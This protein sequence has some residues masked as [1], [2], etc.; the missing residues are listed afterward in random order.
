MSTQT[1]SIEELLGNA[2]WMERFAHTLC[3][4]G[5]DLA[6]DA[7]IAA[8]ES[9]AP[10]A[11][12]GRAWFAT[13]MR[14]AFRMRL[15]SSQRRTLREQV[16]PEPQQPPVP[17]VLTQRLLVE[18]RLCDHVLLLTESQREVILLHFYEGMSA[19]AIARQL[20]VPATTIRS[21]LERSLEVL[22]EGLDNESNGDREAWQL[23]L[24]SLSSSY[25]PP[26]SAA[27]GTALGVLAM[28]AKV[29]IAIGIALLLLIGG[30]VKMTIAMQTAKKPVP[31]SAATSEH[32]A[33]FAKLGKEGKQRDAINVKLPSC[34]I[35]GTVRSAD[36]KTTLA[37]ALVLSS[38]DP[39]VISTADSDGRF[40][41]EN[42]PEG[43]LGL[44]ASAEEHK[45]ALQMVEHQCG[46]EVSLVLERGGV[47]VE[48]SVQD[49]GGGTV[50]QASVGLAAVRQH[51][52]GSLPALSDE[53]GH[54]SLRV[55]AG[56]YGLNAYHPAYV[57]SNEFLA[58]GGT[59]LHRDIVLLPAGGIQ[60]RVTEAESGKA[61]ALASIEV[62]GAL[63]GA[64]ASQIVYSDDEG[65]FALSGLPPGRTQLRIRAVGLATNFEIELGLAEER[66]DVEIELGRGF[67]LAG[68]VVEK[69]SDK[70]VAKATIVVVNPVTGEAISGQQ[71]TSEDGHFEIHGLMPGSYIV[72]ATA[73]NHLTE[74]QFNIVEVDSDKN[75]LIVELTVGRRI[76]G[77]IQP[78]GPAQIMVDTMDGGVAYASVL[79]MI[80]VNDIRADEQG[81]F[82]LVGMPPVP[83]VI[84]GTAADGQTGEAEV[85]I[86][87]SDVLLTLQE[88][89]SITG[90]LIDDVGSPLVGA[91]ISLDGTPSLMGGLRQ[92]LGMGARS[93]EK[94]RFRLVGLEP[95]D[96]EL[97]AHDDHGERELVSRPTGIRD[98]EKTGSNSSKSSELGAIE[99]TE[100]GIANLEVR[101]ARA[102][103]TIEGVVLDEAGN[104]VADA[105]VQSGPKDAPAK[106]KDKSALTDGNGQFVLKDLAEGIY[107]LTP[108]LAN[109]EAMGATTPVKVGERAEL[110]IQNLVEV[111]FDID[112]KTK[113]ETCDLRLH[114]A[115]EIEMRRPASKAIVRVRPGDHI[116]E[117][118]CESGYARI[119][120]TLATGSVVVELD[121]WATLVGRFTDKEGRVI[122]GLRAFAIPAEKRSTKALALR[123]LND[124]SV[125][126]DN[127]RVLLRR[128]PPGRFKLVALPSL[129]ELMA[130]GEKRSTWEFSATSGE[131]LDVGTLVLDAHAAS[132]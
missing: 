4:D 115:T 55:D 29:K 84:R 71:T 31:A 80:M 103:H 99:L 18:R 91:W 122:P 5:D 78:P 43:E 125:V 110:R 75:D 52:V 113:N 37:H 77:R 20:G 42:A 69:G 116:V 100:R 126:D 94:G 105:W 87:A 16:A 24:V 46:R 132:Q 34:P 117:V 11:E 128:V 59:K 107:E 27:S 49:I 67:T 90:R 12:Q 54:Y 48:G 9:G 109:G 33:R 82:E 17:D 22:R 36:D 3:Q 102:D 92:K 57:S 81:N 112:V 1:H 131:R 89:P 39:K 119:E 101:V 35:H 23:A 118:E 7:W 130:D 26:A 121:A 44:G 15:R 6:Q 108:K 83:L 47:L 32:E 13:V 97:H 120:K 28:S 65:R 38:S 74:M 60:G 88:R 51:A 106:S 73:A 96:Y 2:R 70:P 68:Y 25:V 98:S 50:A 30:A 8:L 79:S 114:G 127:G 129:T 95:G 111:N 56:A 86:D 53:N 85:G 61:V 76:I 21:R 124:A 72:M 45:S 66:V 93:D 14:N 64:M 41:I 104:P 123:M 62:I 40:V 63:A 19:A 58:V 10:R